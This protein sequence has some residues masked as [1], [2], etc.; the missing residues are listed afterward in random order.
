[1]RGEL[2]RTAVLLT[3]PLRSPARWRVGLLAVGTALAGAGL[4]AGV[5]GVT[6]AGAVLLLAAELVA[7]RLW[8]LAVAAP[9]LPGELR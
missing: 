3:G 9:R 8:F 5:A 4:A 6:I 1:M 2:A 7:R